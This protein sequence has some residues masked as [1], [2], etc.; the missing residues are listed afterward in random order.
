[1][2]VCTNLISYTDPQYESLLILSELP[3]ISC[4]QICNVTEL[5]IYGR[6]LSELINGDLQA[7]GTQMCMNP[8]VFNGKQCVCEVGY[9]LS[10][11]KCYNISMSFDN[12]DQY[13]YQNNSLLYNT[14]QSNLSILQ[15]QITNNK[16]NIENKL[17]SSTQQLIQDISSFRDALIDQIVIVNVSISNVNQNLTNNLQ[18]LNQDLINTKN[19]FSSQLSTVNNSLYT[20]IEQNTIKITDLKN[21]YNN[22]VNA[23]ILNNSMQQAE[24]STINS[25]IQTVGNQLASVNSVLSAGVNALNSDLANY[26]AQQ[27]GANAAIHIAL[28]NLASYDQ[29]LL[30]RINDQS[31]TISNMQN[32]ISSLQ[33]Q[34]DLFTVQNI[35]V[36][37]VVDSCGE[38]KIQVCGNGICGNFQ[39]QSLNVYCDPG[40]SGSCSSD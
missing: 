18:V 24:I 14:L 11:A 8:F 2:Q 29:Y 17:D 33:S 39:P 31:T 19:I 25:N 6:C 21:Q 35:A 37:N 32:T 5:P 34:I 38:P 7:N 13:I 28:T 15:I 3:S 30:Q 36:K 22:F 9:Y 10:N 26:K 12:L 27:N 40:C 1:M 23:A 16:L 20:L 4:S